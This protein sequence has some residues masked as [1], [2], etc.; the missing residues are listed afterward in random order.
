M[1]REKIIENTVSQIERQYG[2]GS[3]MKLG[4][5]GALEGIESISTGSLELIAP[6]VLAGYPGEG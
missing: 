1:E 6:L 4:E 3:I 2:V 5:P